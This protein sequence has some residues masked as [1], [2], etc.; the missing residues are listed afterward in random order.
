MRR[1]W[2]ALLSVL[3]VAALVYLLFFTSMLGVR[4]VEVLGNA[5]VSTE[6]VL[7]AAGVPDRES[8]FVLDTDHIQERVGALPGVA[9]VD[10]SRSWPSTVTIEVSERTPIGFYNTGEKLHLVDGTGVVYK[11]IPEKPSGLPELKLPRVAPEDPVTRAVTG[12]LVAI[13]KDLRDRVVS[14]SAKT[15]GSVVLTLNDGKTVRWGD[16]DQAGR[17]AKV[18]AVLLTREGT[19]YDVSSPELPTVS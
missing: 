8:M 3:T 6:K 1:R 7:T 16:A 15:A 17:K 4:S 12:V 18:L 13:P 19:N 5:A 9:T 2:V 14:A 11:E 10:V